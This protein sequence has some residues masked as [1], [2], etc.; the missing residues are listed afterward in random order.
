MI[1]PTDKLKYK[2]I[3]HI[4]KVYPESP[5]ITGS[6]ILLIKIETDTPVVI[7]KKGC[8][9]F[10]AGYYAYVGSAF[11]SGGLAARVGRHLRQ[12]KK[13]HWHIDY[14]LAYG[15]ITEVLLSFVPQNLECQ[16]AT[17]I[18]QLAG[19]QVMFG[20][21]ASDCSCRSHL[22]YVDHAEITGWFSQ[23]QQHPLMQVVKC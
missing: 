2:L 13:M 10:S 18:S 8:F 6:Y 17:S 23:L 4:T 16:W 20:L 7:G 12:H 21:G 3:Q 11:G 1:P 14:V 5:N 19:S 15:R 22:F 9:D